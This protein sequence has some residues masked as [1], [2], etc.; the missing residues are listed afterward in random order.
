MLKHLWWLLLLSCSIFAYDNRGFPHQSPN[1]VTNYPTPFRPQ[2]NYYQTHHIN[3]PPNTINLN[4]PTPNTIFLNRPNAQVNTYRPP[5]SQV[6]AQ[7]NKHNFNVP[8]AIY[9]TNSLYP[10]YP[11]TYGYTSY[12]NSYLNDVPSVS[13]TEISNSVSNLQNQL[14]S[15]IWQSASQGNIPEGAIV[16]QNINR[17]DTF[18]CRANYH[19]TTFYGMV[20]QGEGCYIQQGSSTIRFTQYE[21]LVQSY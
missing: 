19:D 16:Y 5:N 13:I 21:V 8:F 10:Y 12:D 7:Y 11:T 1:A 3:N 6:P 9:Y 4:Q 20:I 2:P 18:Y 17:S 15:G 14:P